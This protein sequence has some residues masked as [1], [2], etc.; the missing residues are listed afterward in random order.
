M[1]AVYVMRK[2]KGQ[3]QADEDCKRDVEEMHSKRKVIRPT[4]VVRDEVGKW[5][6]DYAKVM[7]AMSI[8]TD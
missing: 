5:T 6:E 8:P 1:F 3:A 2:I 4:L 7:N